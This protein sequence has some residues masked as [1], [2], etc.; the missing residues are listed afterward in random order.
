MTK[1]EMLELVQA[2]GN[3]SISA[4]QYSFTEIKAVVRAANTSG[5][6]VRLTDCNVY[7]CRTLCDIAATSKGTVT[8]DNLTIDDLAID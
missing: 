8:F 5:A 3:V 2:G 6:K 4:R 1:K 7:T